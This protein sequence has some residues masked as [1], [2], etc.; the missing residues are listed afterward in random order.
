[1]LGTFVGTG[2]DVSCTTNASGSFAKNGSPGRLLLVV[3]NLGPSGDAVDVTVDLAA[4]GVAEGATARLVPGNAPLAFTGFQLTGPALL[5]M[6]HDCP[7]ALPPG[8]LC[9]ARLA[10]APDSTNP[11]SSASTSGRSAASVR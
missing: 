3:G 1:M 5:S 2:E 6:T 11:M 7:A 4:A 9:R 8:A 10:F